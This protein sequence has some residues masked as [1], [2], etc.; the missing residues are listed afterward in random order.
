MKKFF[1]TM[2]CLSVVALTASGAMAFSGTFLPGA[3]ING[4]VHDMST[5]AYAAMPADPIGG[6]ICIFCHAPH[7]TIKLSTANGGTALGSNVQAPDAFTYLPLWNHQLTAH[8]P[9]SY[10]MYWNGPGAPQTGSHASQAIAL[11]MAPGSVSLLCLSCHDGSVAVNSYGTGPNGGLT[12]IQ[13]SGS[14]SG[15]GI[16]IN[17]AYII[18]QD[19]ILQNH[20]PIGFDYNLVQAADTEIRPSSTILSNY[21]GNAMSIQDHLYGAS[22]ISGCTTGNCLECGSCH[23]VH[24]KSNTGERL[25]WRTDKNSALCLTCH[26]KGTYTTPETAPSGPLP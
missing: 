10:S 23:S 20:H 4:T 24:N 7:N 16:T 2:L 11:G 8:D 12:N 14:Y 17:S 9:S 3:G 26:D 5:G 1:I 6:R 22:V 25:L 19:A 15:G 21:N 13:P 18:G